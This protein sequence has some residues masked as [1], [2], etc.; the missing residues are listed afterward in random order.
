ML[1][2]ALRVFFIDM[3][4]HVQKACHCTTSEHWTISEAQTD[5]NTK[6]K[7]SM[8][9]ANY[10]GITRDVVMKA[11]QCFIIWNGQWKTSINDTTISGWS[12]NR[13]SA[14]QALKYL[15]GPYERQRTQNPN[16]ELIW[17][18]IWHIQSAME[19]ERGLLSGQMHECHQW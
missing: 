9:K 15:H 10:Y 14:L 1:Y 3:H 2:K 19:V 4:K 11:S 18:G 7:S 5:R 13:L 16:T 6:G 8:H 12:S 17:E